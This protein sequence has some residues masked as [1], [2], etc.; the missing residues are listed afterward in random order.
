MLYDRVI[1]Y[2]AMKIFNDSRVILCYFCSED[3]QLKG[4]YLLYQYEPCQ[5][6]SDSLRLQGEHMQL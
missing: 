4:E 5:P 2:D 1:L 3:L 6:Q